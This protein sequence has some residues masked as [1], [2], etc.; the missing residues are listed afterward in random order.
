MELTT[1]QATLLRTIAAEAN[2]N[3]ME[4]MQ[5]AKL[6]LGAIRHLKGQLA[7]AGLIHAEG[8][9]A[10]EAGEEWVAANPP[11][12]KGAASGNQ[13]L[14]QE[15]VNAIRA[16]RAEPN[17]DC[18]GSAHTHVQVGEAFGVSPGV[19]SMIC[20]N[21]SYVDRDYVPLWDGFQDLGPRKPKA[22]VEAE[23]EEQEAAEA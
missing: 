5:T 2:L 9:Q 14:S 8:A 7:E 12:A 22:E 1:K 15:V 17:E 20:R 4:L 16:M 6:P 18:T 10:T 3:E 19:V 11:K 13:R 21:R 23:A